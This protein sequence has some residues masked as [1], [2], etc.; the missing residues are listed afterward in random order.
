MDLEI[1]L[2]AVRAALWNGGREE[3]YDVLMTYEETVHKHFDP[4]SDNNANAFLEDLH[5]LEKLC[6]RDASIHD[7]STI[8]DIERLIDR[9]ADFAHYLSR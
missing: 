8:R 9:A 4:E 1:F 5:D 3:L 6:S 7:R 2:Y